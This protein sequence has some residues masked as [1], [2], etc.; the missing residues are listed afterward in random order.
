MVCGGFIE[1]RRMNKT[2]LNKLFT[3]TLLLLLAGCAENKYIKTIDQICPPGAAR[4]DAMAAGEQVLGEMHFAIEKLDAETGYIRSYPL[5]GAQTF[6]F[7]RK[8]NVGSFN[9]AE[10]DLH[11]IRRTVELNINQQAGQLCINCKV[12]TQQLSLPQSQTTA[13]QGTLTEI[14]RSVQKLKLSPEQKTNLIWIDLGRDNQLETE[15]INRITKQLNAVKKE[16]GK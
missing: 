11:S 14:R 13:G 3:W 5:A 2:I 1:V 6:E 4:A 7:W 12:M 10:A 8:D 15:I 16:Q 9:Q